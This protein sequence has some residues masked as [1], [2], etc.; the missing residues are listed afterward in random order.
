LRLNTA[1]GPSCLFASQ[2][3]KFKL[4]LTWLCHVLCKHVYSYKD[5]LAVRSKPKTPEPV[6]KSNS[7]K[8]KGRKRLHAPSESDPEESGSEE[9]DMTAGTRTKK[10]APKIVD[11]AAL[12]SI[13]GYGTPTKSKELA[14]LYKS[15]EDSSK[16][17]KKKPKKGEEHAPSGAGKKLSLEYRKTPDMNKRNYADVIYAL[18][19]VQRITQ[20]EAV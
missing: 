10:S 12:S 4:N 18:K 5:K 11:P 14:A 9:I 15:A 1:F 2:S 16:Q 17:K 19:E 6:L 3:T 8:S 20:T 7:K 13:G